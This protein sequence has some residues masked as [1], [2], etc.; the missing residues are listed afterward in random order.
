MKVIARGAMC[1][2]DTYLKDGWNVMDGILVVISLINILFDLIAA[3]SPKIFG[4]I[5]VLRCCVI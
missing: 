2:P 5:R 4:V 1:G 3:D